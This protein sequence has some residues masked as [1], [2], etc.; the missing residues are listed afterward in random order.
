MSDQ[1]PDN[2]NH[3][4][5]SQTRDIGVLVVNLHSINNEIRKGYIATSSTSFERSW[6]R[7]ATAPFL[8]ALKP[9]HN[10]GSR[11]FNTVLCRF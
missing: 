9:G 7:G 3:P 10:W 11:T 6:E 4:R 8:S 1:F 5:I 2:G